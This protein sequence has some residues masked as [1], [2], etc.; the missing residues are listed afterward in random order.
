MD[1]NV[2][3]QIKRELARADAAW[4]ALPTFPDDTKPEQKQ[5]I[6]A[7]LSDLRVDLAEKLHYLIDRVES[8]ENFTK[9]VA[10]AASNR[11]AE[12]DAVPFDGTW[13]NEEKLDGVRVA[14]FYTLV[15]LG[16]E[17]ERLLDD[18]AAKNEQGAH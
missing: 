10:K 11:K 15:N 3:E 6:D 4:E 9:R 18:V 14:Y 1:D 2:L 16:K 5:E 17:A 12:W 13:Q 7:A 8:L